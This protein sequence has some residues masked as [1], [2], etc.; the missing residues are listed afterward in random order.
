MQ[1]FTVSKW[2]LAPA[3]ISGHL[4]I[5][6]ALSYFKALSYF[7]SAFIIFQSAFIFLSKRFHILKALSYFKSAFIIFQSAFIFLSKRFY[8]LSQRF[9]LNFLS[10]SQRLFIFLWVGVS[11]IYF[12]FPKHYSALTVISRCEAHNF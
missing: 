2:K 1:S 7:Q 3:I 8:F 10:V 11:T 9:H 5:F 4:C 6:I 12:L